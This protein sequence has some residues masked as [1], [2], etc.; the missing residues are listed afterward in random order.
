M[1]PRPGKSSKAPSVSSTDPGGAMCRDGLVFLAHGLDVDAIVG[2]EVRKGNWA[3]AGETGLGCGH[4]SRPLHCLARQCRPK[5]PERAWMDIFKNATRTIVRSVSHLEMD[6]NVPG[7]EREPGRPRH[8]MPALALETVSR[9]IPGSAAMSVSDRPTASRCLIAS[10]S[11][12]RHLKRRR[13]QVRRRFP[14]F[15]G[16]PN[17]LD[18][19]ETSL[20]F[21]R[22]PV[23]SSRQPAGG[24]HERGRRRGFA[25]TGL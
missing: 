17:G 20:R 5:R 22:R 19:P 25:R 7:R 8:A 9:D 15:T 4:R 18:Q 2:V 16:L 10:M 21:G 14:L 11:I 1:P 12:A 6:D 13:L 24:N 23:G 3:D